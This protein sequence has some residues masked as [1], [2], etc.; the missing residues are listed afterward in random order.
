MFYQDEPISGLDSQTAWSICMLL[1]KLAANGQ[2][3]LCTVHQPSAQLFRLFDRLLLLNNHGE[4]VYFG[5][6]G[7]DVQTLIDYFEGRGAPKCQPGNNPADWAL[8]I[9]NDTG[10]TSAVTAAEME[11]SPEA[12]QPREATGPSWSKQWSESQQHHDTQ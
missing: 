1:C 10:S 6:I 11:L 8:D 7:P 9:T 4:T 5:D 3:V 2:A 12:E